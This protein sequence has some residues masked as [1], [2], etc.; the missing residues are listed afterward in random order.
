MKFGKTLNGYEG[1]YQV[2][3]FGRV[4]SLPKFHKMRKDDDIGFTSNEIILKNCSSSSGYYKVTLCKN[5][6]KINVNIHKLVA[7]TFI[8]NPNNYTT[9]NHKDGNKLNNR[10]DNLEWCTQLH[11]VREAIK[12]GFKKN[13][14]GIKI[15]QYDINE[16]YIKT[17]NSITEASK[18]LNINKSHICYCCKRKRKTAGGFIWRYGKN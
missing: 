1:L 11:N 18:Q 14:Y 12:L 2:S 17:W 9:I 5:K 7:I 8:E 3:N 4:K 16:K 6:K 10:V 15:N 13:T